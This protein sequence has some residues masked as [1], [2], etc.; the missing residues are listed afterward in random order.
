[1]EI[2]RT[3]GVKEYFF[4]I[5]C[6]HIQNFKKLNYYYKNKKNVLLIVIYNF[7]FVEKEK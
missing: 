4:Q 6:T 7:K 5:N 1:M 2:P 3:E